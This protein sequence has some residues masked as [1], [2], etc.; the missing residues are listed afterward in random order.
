MPVTTISDPSVATGGNGTDD[1][2]RSAAGSAFTLAQIGTNT[3]TAAYNLAVA[4]GSAYGLAAFNIAVAGTNRANAAYALAM[5]GTNTGTAAYAL[6]SSALVLA[7]AGS[8]VYHTA[9]T[10]YVRTDGNDNNTGTVNTSGGAFLTLQKA[11]NAVT[12]RVIQSGSEVI[13]QLADGTY[14]GGVKVYPGL[15]GGAVRLVGNKSTP[16]NTFVQGSSTYGIICYNSNFVVEALKIA[17]TTSH[18]LWTARGGYMQIDPNVWFGSTAGYACRAI[19][20]SVI[21]INGA[22]SILGGGQG[23][24]IAEK[25]STINFNVATTHTLFSTPSYTIGF[26]NATTTGQTIAISQAFSGAALG[27]RYSAN[28]NSVINTNGGG[29]SYFPG[30]QT[31]VTS[32]GGQYA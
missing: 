3:G 7:Q 14:S 25:G 26:A 23:F 17:S 21:A 27:P 6:A 15:G 1:G 10:Y 4:G 29:A 18:A 11:V 13:I 22:V 12:S 32:T 2:A 24:C 16:T 30:N 19:D 28:L 8:N 31:G 9:G 20:S 5:T